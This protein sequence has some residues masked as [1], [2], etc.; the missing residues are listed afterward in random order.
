MGSAALK[1]PPTLVGGCVNGLTGSTGPLLTH[2][3]REKKESLHRTATPEVLA[4]DQ[5]DVGFGNFLAELQMFQ[6]GYYHVWVSL[7]EYL[8]DL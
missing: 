6:E 8:P 7:W 1:S 5:G 3:G 4:T 2:K